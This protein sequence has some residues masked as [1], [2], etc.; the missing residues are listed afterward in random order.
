MHQQ[1]HPRSYECSTSSRL[2][3]FRGY[4]SCFFS[5]FSGCFFFFATLLLALALGSFETLCFELALPLT[6]AAVPVPAA[7]LLPA[8]DD[9]EE[10]PPPVPVVALAPLPIAF[11]F[12][13]FA[14]FPADE[15]LEDELASFFA[16]AF[17]FAAALLG[18]GLTTTAPLFILFTLSFDAVRARV[19][20]D[21]KAPDPDAGCAFMAEELLLPPFEAVLP[22]EVVD[23]E[24]GTIFMGMDEVDAAAAFMGGAALLLLVVPEEDATAKVVEEAVACFEFVVTAGAAEQEDVA[25]SCFEAADPCREGGCFETFFSTPFFAAGAEVAPAAD[26]IDA[27]AAVDGAAACSA[28]AGRDST[29]FGTNMQSSFACGLPLPGDFCRSAFTFTSVFVSAAVIGPLLPL[30]LLLC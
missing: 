19:A 4:L 20:F 6:A 7:A 25:D 22:V 2:Y 8:L 10:E 11:A 21:A 29:S 26:F 1:L 17:A 14:L 9:D 16:V 24:G 5:S 18:A 30:P 3:I 13:P 23:V 12:P 15:L 28:P 27:G